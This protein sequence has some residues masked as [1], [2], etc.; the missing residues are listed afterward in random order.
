MDPQKNRR[1]F[2][3][4]SALLGALAYT[5][6]QSF[7]SVFSSAKRSFRMSLNPGAVGVNLSLEEL[8]DMAVKY[9]FEAIVPFA[10]TLAEWENSRIDDFVEQMKSRN[11]SWGA[12][13]LPMNFRL[14]KETHLKG[15]HALPKYA[16]ALHKA[17]VTRMSTWIMPTHPYLTYMEN[18]KQH[19]ARLKEVCRIVGDHG[20]N[21]GLEY[22]GPKTL[23]T[24]QKFSFVR[25]M[26]ECRE[27]I[28]AID[29]PN[30]GFQLDS[31]HW[32]CAGETREDLLSLSNEDIITVD[33]NDARQGFSADEQI[34][35]KRELPMATG[36]VDL[37][38]FMEALVA[39]GYDGPVRAEPFN[40]A[41]N[42]L[43]NEAALSKTAEAMKKA[44]ALV[45]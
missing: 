7:A 2:I 43:E 27:L 41:L 26:A 21:F 8:L 29:E 34:D 19:A 35:G 1:T 3:K 30:A 33:L 25:T 11:I 44:F 32:Y 42:D 9:G 4:K 22:V 36:V 16:W 18:M 12:A 37:K 23:M 39:I 28:G 6:M 38:S 31:F 13:G 24:S 10:D 15:L 14:D 5:P 45:S 40:Q 17:G 20:I